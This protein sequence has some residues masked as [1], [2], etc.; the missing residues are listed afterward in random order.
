MIDAKDLGR[1]A[2]IGAAHQAPAMHEVGIAEK[3]LVHLR[4]SLAG[5]DD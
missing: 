2:R 3:V 5:A 1:G 4:R